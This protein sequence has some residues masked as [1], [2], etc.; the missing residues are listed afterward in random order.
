[1]PDLS[2]TGPESVLAILL[3]R[4]T[5]RSPARAA[6]DVSTRS[7]FNC[8]AQ[9]CAYAVWGLTA[10]AEEDLDEDDEEDIEDFD[11]DD[12]EDFDD[13]DFLDDEDDDDEDD[14]EQPDVDESKID[15]DRA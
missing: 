13:D 6:R 15:D 2:V 11:D 10:E 12:E 14:D 9:W 3:T 4:T 7:M 1:M 8:L 5:A